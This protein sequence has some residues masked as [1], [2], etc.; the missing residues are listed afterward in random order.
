ME[1]CPEG[2][3]VNGGKSP[4]THTLSRRLS[5]DCSSEIPDLTLT[6]KASSE[7]VVRPYR[8]PTQVGEER[9][10]RRSGEL[11]LRNSAKSPRNFGRRGAPLR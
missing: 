10:L 11:S 9:I 5:E 7:K 3:R 8:K 2:E 6:R 1:F 4:F